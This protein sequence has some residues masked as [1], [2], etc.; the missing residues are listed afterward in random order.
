[1]TPAVNAEAQPGVRILVVDD[2]ADS[3]DSMAKLLQIFG[4]E[5]LVARDGPQAIAAAS[6]W[7]PEFVLLDLGLPVMDGYEVAMRMRDEP[8]CPRFVIIAMTGYGQPAD[9]RRSLAVGIEH[10]LVKPVHPDVL[11]PLLSRSVQPSSPE[12]F[13]PMGADS[14]AA[15][16]E[17]SDTGADSSAGGGWW[18]VG[19]TD[20]PIAGRSLFDVNS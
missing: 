6:R 5:V 8:S 9:R 7:R 3:A 12:L 16:V 11:L 4:H 17:S 1:M 2:N 10:H 13:S 20:G 18:D 15:R 19:S 14:S